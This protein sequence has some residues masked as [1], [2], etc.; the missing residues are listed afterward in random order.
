[1]VTCYMK[2]KNEVKALSENKLQINNFI[3]VAKQCLIYKFDKEC[4]VNTNLISSIYPYLFNDMTD[5]KITN[6]IENE[7]K[8]HIG[9][10]YETLVPQEIKK[11]LGQFY[12]RD[13]NVVNLMIKNVDILSGRILE[14]SC[15]SGIFM[16]EIVD[17]MICELK[18][19]GASAIEILDYIVDNLY[20]NDKDEIALE[21]TEINILT[22]LLPLMIEAKNMDAK[23]VMG[24]LKLTKYSFEEKRCFNKQFSLVIGNPPFVT[25][26]GKRSRN[27][28]EAKRAY[29][30]TFDF[31]QN[32]TGNNKFN[33]AMFFIENGLEIL[34]EKGKMLYILD[35]AF[36]ETAY[37]DIR[38]YIVQNYY[39]NSIIIG[40]Q[41]F[42]DVAS[43]QIILCIENINYK[44]PE[45][46]IIDYSTGIKNIIDQC[47]WDNEKNNF[48]FFS[49]LNNTESEIV[50][51]IEKFNR[52]D[53]IFSGKSLRTCCALTGK[54]DEFIVDSNCSTECEVFPYIEGSKGLKGKFYKP[55]PQRAIK[56]D[57]D[58]Q[59]KL[60]DEFKI[61][62]GKLGIK[63]KKRVTLGDKDV[64]LSPKIFIRQSANE[65]IA[66][67]TEKPYAAN[68]SIYVLSLK[69]N[70]EHAKK[71][72]RYTCGILNSRLI[73]FYCKVKNIIRSGK[74][75]TPQIKISDLK[76]I[77]LEI[78]DD[79][80]EQV[81]NLVDLL[82]ENPSEQNIFSELD[83]LVY[84]IYGIDKD[85]IEYINTFSEKVK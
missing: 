5:F 11:D 64:Y 20:G 70:D 17:R 65:I 8:D 41:E 73:T 31:V 16:V 59:I 66:T 81:I 60:S 57:Y 77:R 33:L 19:K 69:K 15:G 18:N 12:T 13:Y 52:L 4:A 29:Y 62:L 43:G 28:T 32:K 50:T 71:L 25:M 68:N 55:T 44:N 54:T 63:N 26:Y 34:Q 82:L 67:Y 75:K 36:F 49:P 22:R 35:I 24:K 21:I 7:L 2:T 39:I 30:N 6:P 84:K 83:M 51:K 61:E 45:V 37:I 10:L 56:F 78:S 23:Y 9:Q 79:F 76:E 80:F 40:L 1:M 58:L 14:P 74:G 46:D 72:L 38:K 85:E 53:A 3:K 48:K 27:M 42:V 47:L